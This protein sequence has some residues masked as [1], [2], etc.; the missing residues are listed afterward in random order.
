MDKSSYAARNRKGETE[1]TKKTLSYFSVIDFFG[2]RLAIPFENPLSLCSAVIHAM[3]YPQRSQSDEV[4]TLSLQVAL[5]FPREFLD[6]VH[7]PSSDLDGAFAKRISNQ[8]WSFPLSLSHPPF[9]S[10][11][12]NVQS[13]ERKSAITLFSLEDVDVPT[14]RVYE[15]ERSP[16]EYSTGK[17]LETPYLGQLRRAFSSDDQ[18]DLQVAFLRWLKDVLVLYEQKIGTNLTYIFY[19]YHPYLLKQVKRFGPIGSFFARQGAYEHHQFRRTRQALLQL[20][21]TQ[22]GHSDYIEDI[23]RPLL[24]H[25]Y[26]VQLAA[27][28]WQEGVPLIVVTPYA[29]SSLEFALYYLS[30]SQPP[31]YLGFWTSDEENDAKTVA[32]RIVRSSFMLREKD[33]L[34]VAVFQP[35]KTPQQDTIQYFHCSASGIRL[36]KT[37]VPLNASVPLSDPPVQLGL[38]DS[39]TGL[40]VGNTVIHAPSLQIAMQDVERIAMLRGLDRFDRLKWIDRLLNF[41]LVLYLLHRGVRDCNCCRPRLLHDI[42]SSCA[43]FFAV[44][45]CTREFRS[46][47][48][49]LCYSDFAF[50]RDGIRKNYSQFV[51]DRL[52]SVEKIS[53]L[54]PKTAGQSQV[55]RYWKEVLKLS[56]RGKAY[57]KFWFFLCDAYMAAD[58]EGTHSPQQVWAEALVHYF[59]SSDGDLSR[60]YEVINTHGRMIEFVE[61]TTGSSRR[62]KLTMTPDLLETLIHCLADPGQELL[63]LSDVIRRLYERYGLVINV[64]DAIWLREFEHLEDRKRIEGWISTIGEQNVDALRTMLRE[65]GLLLEYS[66]SNAVVKVHYGRTY[67]SETESEE[68]D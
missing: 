35:G 29:P 57:K 24:L 51:R 8:P 30:H 41:H 61:P 43:R 3:L 48:A 28:D 55:E 9:V 47:V 13:E 27:L 15:E 14:A 1:M 23:V 33:E 39:L 66:D 18:I 44:V 67:P 52:A 54:P 2:F 17:G 65:A 42:P 40:S 4:G 37:I 63:P 36:I 60:I 49:L 20:L 45:D 25:E 16:L 6:M 68:E 22:S 53:P 50:L 21:I 34:A 19:P 5:H 46:D 64:G 58:L 7:S 56:T 12:V 31:C 62:R 32:T 26:A 59:S 10:I 11:P 38:E